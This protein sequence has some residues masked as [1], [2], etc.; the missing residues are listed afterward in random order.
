[1]GKKSENEEYK[2][3]PEGRTVDFELED[4]PQQNKTKQNNKNKNKN[5]IKTNGK[6]KKYV[7]LG[8][9]CILLESHQ[10]DESGSD[11]AHCVF[12]RVIMGSY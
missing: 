7:T 8:K 10:P 4:V 3:D 9:S 1:M 6:N 5:K 2:S 12:P 11:E